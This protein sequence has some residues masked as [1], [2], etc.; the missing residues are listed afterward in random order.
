VEREKEEGSTWMGYITVP[1]RE[2]V[3]SAEIYYK[4]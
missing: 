3:E 4:D 2:N 1:A